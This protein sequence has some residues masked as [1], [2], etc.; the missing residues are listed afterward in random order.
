MKY[1]RGEGFRL[2]RINYNNVQFEN[3]VLHTEEFGYKRKELEPILKNI[4]KSDLTEL[5]DSQK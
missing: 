5:D 4:F 3:R 2:L 1:S